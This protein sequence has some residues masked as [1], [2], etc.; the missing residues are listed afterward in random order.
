LLR[1]LVNQELESLFDLEAGMVFRYA[2]IGD[3]DLLFLTPRKFHLSWQRVDFY[4]NE[5]SY[6]R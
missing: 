6:P 3:L 4:A 2:A 5:H 1:S